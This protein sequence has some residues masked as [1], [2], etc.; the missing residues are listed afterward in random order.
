MHGALYLLGPIPL[1]PEF[2][3]Q[4]TPGVLAAIEVHTP[5]AS[6][7]ERSTRLFRVLALACTGSTVGR[8]MNQ[9]LTGKH[10][11]VSVA[12]NILFVFVSS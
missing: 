2:A 5:G 3:W 7:G 10:I 1:Q 9:R 12:I 4:F 11:L 6:E 8:M